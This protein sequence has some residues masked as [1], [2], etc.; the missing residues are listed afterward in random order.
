MFLFSNSKSLVSISPLTKKFSS[1]FVNLR[2][3]EKSFELFKDKFVSNNFNSF[4]L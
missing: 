3:L 4:S 2:F 1:I